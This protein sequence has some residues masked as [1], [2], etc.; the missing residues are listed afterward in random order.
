VIETMNSTHVP[1]AIR[2][3]TRR[4]ATWPRR[5]RA[6]F[7]SLLVKDLELH[8]ADAPQHDDITVVTGGWRWKPNWEVRSSKLKVKSQKADGLTPPGS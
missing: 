4:R 6:E 7:L 5:P 1:T 2:G 3:F 8:Q